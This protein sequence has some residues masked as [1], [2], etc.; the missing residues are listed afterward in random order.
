ME[1]RTTGHMVWAL[2]PS[3]VWQLVECGS[4]WKTCELKRGDEEDVGAVPVA[5]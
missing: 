4:F 1:M 3:W 2:Q 5:F